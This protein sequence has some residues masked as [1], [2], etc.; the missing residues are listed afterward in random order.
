MTS[1]R[2]HVLDRLNA[3]LDRT[4]SRG[5]DI[6]V[7]KHLAQCGPCNA[8]MVR[9]KR[10]RGLDPWQSASPSVGSGTSRGSG[11]FRVFYSALAIAGLVIAATHLYYGYLK[12]T[13][14]DLRA[15]GQVQWLPG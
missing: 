11:F 4:L 3:Y 2:D 10:Q 12:P 14:Y 15:L 7:R 8:A 6:A 13:P 9:L 1:Q 5:D